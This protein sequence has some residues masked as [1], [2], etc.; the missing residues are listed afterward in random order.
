MRRNYISPEFIKSPIYGTFNM[1]ES[2]NFF[3]TNILNIEDVIYISDQNIIYYQKLNGEQ[4]DISVESSLSSNI[5]SSFEY[6]RLNHTLEIDDTQSNYQKDNNT[7]WILDI[8]YNEILYN[9]IFSIIKKN[10]VFEG[11]INKMTKSNDINTAIREYINKNILK[12]YKLDSI[13][14]YILYSDLVSNNI[15]RYNNIWDDKIVSDDNLLNKK[16]IIYLDDLVE[17]KFTQEKTSK[18]FNFKYYFNLNFKII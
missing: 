17:I 10:R 18:T 16:Q 8:K 11:V 15:L 1:L 2:S 3:G 5:Y 4:I 14:I 13:D 7:K 12:K 9:Y 6:K